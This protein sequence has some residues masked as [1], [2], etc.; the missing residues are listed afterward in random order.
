MK[1]TLF[2]LLISCGGDLDEDGDG[3]TVLT[4]DCDEGDPYINPNGVEVCD[5]I[6]NDCDGETDE[7]DSMD[8]RTHG[9]RP[10]YCALWR[11]QHTLMPATS[12]LSPEGS[13]DP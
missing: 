9:S 6:D 13:L 8:S 12:K 4:G 11:A 10:A 1:K 3:F 5:E 7:D 2:F